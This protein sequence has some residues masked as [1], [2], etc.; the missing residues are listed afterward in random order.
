MVSIVYDNSLKLLS[1]RIINYCKDHNTH[2]LYND[3]FGI[4]EIN[5]ISCDIVVHIGNRSFFKILSKYIWDLDSCDDGE[6]LLIPRL[7]FN[8]KLIPSIRNNDFLHFERI[9]SLCEEIIEILNQIRFNKYY[10]KYELKESLNPGNSDVRPILE[11]LVNNPRIEFHDRSCSICYEMTVSQT[12]C[13]HILCLPCHEK[14]IR[15]HQA[16]CPVC[17]K[18]L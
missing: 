16:N 5:G 1:E 9:Y 15:N 3:F 17:R 6:F 18:S 10:G 7:L 11:S 8:K 13:E 4:K 2:F 12:S 14:L